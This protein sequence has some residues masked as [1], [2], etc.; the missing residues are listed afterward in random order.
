MSNIL[1]NILCLLIIHLFVYALPF[2]LPN[3]GVF[4]LVSI[5]D[6]EVLMK[7]YNIFSLVLL[8]A[9]TLIR[10]MVLPIVYKKLENSRRF[11]LVAKFIQRL[12]Q[13][14]C[15]KFV[16]LVIAYF[17]FWSILFPYFFGGFYLQLSSGL[18]FGLLG[19]YLVLFVYW[20]IEDKIKVGR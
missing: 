12:K 8:V 13:S 9:L 19:D 6:E 18:L 11:D 3:I 10:F 1:K 4:V 2:V 7:Y 5:I 16:V 15:L 14:W 17:S 20:F